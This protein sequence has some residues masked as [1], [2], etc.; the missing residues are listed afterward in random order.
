MQ[1]CTYDAWLWRT[2]PFFQ[3]DLPL[4]GPENLGT[5]HPIYTRRR[6]QV[7]L[8]F[9]NDDVTRIQTS[10][11]FSRRWD[12]LMRFCFV[13]FGLLREDSVIVTV[14]WYDARWWSELFV[15]SFGSWGE[16]ATTWVINLKAKQTRP[17]HCRKLK[18]FFL[19]IIRLSVAKTLLSLLDSCPIQQTFFW[20]QLLAKYY[21]TY[22]TYLITVDWIQCSWHAN[23]PTLLIRCECS[24]IRKYLHLRTTDRPTV[25]LKTWIITA[26]T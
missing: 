6:V 14:K 15:G 3:F 10:L 23:F 13:S 2:R 7:H 22:P 26:N 24:I 12:E 9:K 8:N 19:Q 17:R 1:I 5:M 16:F 25:N 18:T 20:H 21:I 11:F 4:S